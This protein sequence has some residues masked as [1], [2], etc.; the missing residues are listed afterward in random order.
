MIRVTTTYQKS[1]IRSIEVSGH[2]LS[3]EYGKDLVCAGVSAIVTGIANMLVKKDFLESGEI[4]FKNGYV[5]I[6][7]SNENKEHQLILE[8]LMVSLESVEESYDNYIEI[9]K[10]EA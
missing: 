10:K 1:V 3:D 9:I 6:K 8:T 5:L 2:A 4:Q 7:T